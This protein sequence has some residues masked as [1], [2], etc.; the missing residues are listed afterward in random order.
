VFNAFY[1]N[2][3]NKDFTNLFI[4]RNGA[5]PGPSRKLTMIQELIITLLRLRLALSVYIVSI[6]FGVSCSRISSIS[7]T[8]IFCMYF[9]FGDQIIWP[10]KDL[11]QK[12][13]PSVFKKSFPRTR[14]IIDCSEVFIQ[15][16]RTHLFIQKHTVIISRTILLNF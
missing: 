9:I 11:I 8:W 2:F 1:N 13:M 10:S 16:P 7:T 12:H 6:L 3:V 14:A 4:L 15:R 5:K